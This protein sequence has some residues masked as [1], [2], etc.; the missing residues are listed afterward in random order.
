M[1]SRDTCARVAAG[2][3]SNLHFV[4]ESDSIRNIGHL[5][6]ALELQTLRPNCESV[7]EEKAILIVRW[8]SPLSRQQAE[9]G[10]V[11]TPL[12]NAVRRQKSEGVIIET[13]AKSLL[14]SNIFLPFNA[15]RNKLHCILPC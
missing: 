4:S 7:R 5:N 13:G 3:P 2:F 6:A 1:S 9:R 14:T 11:R 12:R 10:S 15:T 8:M